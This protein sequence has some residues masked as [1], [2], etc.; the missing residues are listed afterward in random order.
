M[1]DKLVAFD[2]RHQNSQ[3]NLDGFFKT[4]EKQKLYTK[5]ITRKTK[6]LG[7]EPFGIYLHMF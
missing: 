4:F 7:S 2:S 3:I 5:I 1:K 6:I